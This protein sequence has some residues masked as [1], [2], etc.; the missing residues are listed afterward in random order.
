MFLSILVYIGFLALYFGK[1]ISSVVYSVLIEPHF[2]STKWD[3]P[4]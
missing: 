4:S 3:F 1:Q 2:Y